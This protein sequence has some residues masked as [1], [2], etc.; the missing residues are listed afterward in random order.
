MTYLEEPPDKFDDKKTV[1]GIST[2]IS[3][4]ICQGHLGETE[5]IPKKSLLN[6][7]NDFRGI[8]EEIL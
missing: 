5:D 1:V 4:E 6:L 8:L 3:L 2:E 7:R